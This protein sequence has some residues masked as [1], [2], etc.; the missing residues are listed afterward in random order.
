MYGLIT[1]IIL[2][3]SQ[4]LIKTSGATYWINLIWKIPWKIKIYFDEV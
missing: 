4:F 2:D 1:K 3:I